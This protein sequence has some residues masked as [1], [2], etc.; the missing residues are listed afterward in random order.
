MAIQQR[1]LKFIII[2]N[3]ILL[4]AATVTGFL[5]APADFAVAVVIGGLIAAVNFQLLYRTLKKSLASP[6]KDSLNKVLA[7][8]YVRFLVTCT[9][10]FILISRGY[11]E[12]P[13]LLVGLSIVVA[14]IMLATVRELT[15]II[16]FKEAV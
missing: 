8:Y 7:K 5:T 13:G 14:S 6:K 2:S 9:I 10:I 12:P 15:K 11:V 16:F 3:W 4:A 1:L